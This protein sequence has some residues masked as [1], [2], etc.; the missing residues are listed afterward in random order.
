MTGSEGSI[1]DG[2]SLKRPVPIV[3]AGFGPFGSKRKKRRGNPAGELVRKLRKKG[4]GSGKFEFVDLK[5]EWNAYEDLRPGATQV[6]AFVL[7]GSD[8]RCSIPGGPPLRIETHATPRRS[9]NKDVH[10]DRSP[11]A[12]SGEVLAAD[13][14]VV[15]RMVTE[16]D[17][18]AAKGRK[19]SAGRYVCNWTFY[20]ALETA[21]APAFFIHIPSRG[22]SD[23]T[24]TGVERALAACDRAIPYSA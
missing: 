14:R 4:F 17:G 1:G 23:R 12:P 9:R 19:K 22:L 20:R 5:T 21:D 16:A 2:A 7:I 3:V 13:S 24:R 6:R 8:W 18:T 10:G 15:S 11:K